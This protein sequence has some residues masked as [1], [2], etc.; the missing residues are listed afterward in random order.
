V[1]TRSAP[2]HSLH[3]IGELLEMIGTVQTGA[4][5]F[6]F[7][8]RRR[9]HMHLEVED[10]GS[11]Q[12]GVADVVRIADPRHRLALNRAAL[13]DE[14][15]DVGHDLA[16]VVF[17]GQA[18]DHRHARVGSEALDDFLFEGADHDDVA[19]ARN[20]LRRIL[21]RLAATQLRIAGIEIDGRTAQLMHAG[22]ERQ[23]VRVLAF[24]KIITSVRSA[25]ASTAGRT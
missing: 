14:G 15:K 16:G 13:F 24:S 17:V 9:R 19:H 11:L 12:P 8:A 20:H 25:A 4:L 3:R 1:V 23:R 10:L 7:V 22:F 21:D 5:G 18:V 2:A 6:D